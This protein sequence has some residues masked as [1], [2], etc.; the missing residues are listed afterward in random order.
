MPPVV[1]NTLIS[2]RQAQAPVYHGMGLDS[3]FQKAKG[4]HRP[5]SLERVVEPDPACLKC[6]TE[7]G[8][9]YKDHRKRHQGPK[10]MDR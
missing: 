3:V 1:R 7:G 8:H 4:P 2:G 9:C 10:K 5:R 6:F